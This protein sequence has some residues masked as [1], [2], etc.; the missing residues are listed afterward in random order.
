MKFTLYYDCATGWC[1]INN[2][3]YCKICKQVLKEFI[4]SVIDCGLDVTLIPL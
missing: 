1:K 4:L 2:D 3:P